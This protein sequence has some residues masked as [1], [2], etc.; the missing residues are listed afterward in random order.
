MKGNKEHLI[1]HRILGLIFAIWHDI[2]PKNGG[3]QW[4][5]H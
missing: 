3:L 2:L 4:K 5:Q 1:S